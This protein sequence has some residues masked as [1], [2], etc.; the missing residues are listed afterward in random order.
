[1]KKLLGIVVLGL[2]LLCSN[3]FAN[4][5]KKN[6]CLNG[7]KLKKKN[8]CF[9]ILYKYSSAYY[10]AG[11][12][13]LK[14]PKWRMFG[15][16]IAAQFY[17]EGNT[18]DEANAAALAKCQNFTKNNS[19]VLGNKSSQKYSNKRYC[20]LMWSKAIKTKKLETTMA[21]NKSSSTQTS[22]AQ[23]IQSINGFKNIC[24]DIGYKDGTEKMA[25]C[26]KDL[27]LKQVN[28]QSSTTTTKRKIDPSFWD[29]II[30]LS[31]G[32][33]NGSSKTSKSGTVCFKTGEETGG[34]NKVCK[35]S[36]TGSI[37]TINIGAAQICPMKINK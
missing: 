18:S 19:N 35:Y 28:S 22:Q 24:R 37:T 26:V 20:F 13:V 34:H 33:M 32:V 27:Y 29:D 15:N 31:S 36:C 17:S 2:L 25:D 10:F 12:Q 11:Y 9:N 3:A 8:H 30:G 7:S 5:N 4:S 6:E 14:H 16:K 23:N 21:Q 1:M